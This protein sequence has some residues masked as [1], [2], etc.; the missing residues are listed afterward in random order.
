ML[1]PRFD[2]RFSLSRL[3]TPSTSGAKA[4]TTKT[5]RMLYRIRSSMDQLRGHALKTARQQ[6]FAGSRDRR[7][8]VVTICEGEALDAIN[9]ATSTLWPFLRVHPTRGAC[10]A[11]V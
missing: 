5:W 10:G 11:T 8:A 7:A 6:R 4:T 2:W 9:I 3:T 1:G